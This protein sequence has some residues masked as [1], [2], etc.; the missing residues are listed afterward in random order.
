MSRLSVR[1]RCSQRNDYNVLGTPHNNLVR[2]STDKRFLIF[3]DLEETRC[4]ECL[5][6]TCLPS[7]CDEFSEIEACHTHLNSLKLLIPIFWL[8]GHLQRHNF[9]VSD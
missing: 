6:H 3:T 5:K 2:K 4:L 1:V 7:G 9:A 8:Q